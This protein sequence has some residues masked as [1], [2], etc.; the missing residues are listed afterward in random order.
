[1][2][3]TVDFYNI[4]MYIFKALLVITVVMSVVL[5]VSYSA[6]DKKGSVEASYVEYINEWEVEDQAG[7]TFMEKGGY[8]DDRMHDEDFT[9]RARLPKS[10]PDGSYVCFITRCETE[11]YID[12]ELRNKFDR[13]KDVPIRGGSVKN[14]YMLT[15]VNEKD[16][17]KVIEIF[18][19]RV[20]R[21]PEIIPEVFIAGRGGL[22]EV[23]VSKY[24]VSF[25]ISVI[26]MFI[27]T[28]VV[29]VGLGMR[30]FY[31]REIN[32]L[33]AALGVCVTSAWLITNSYLFP[34]AFGHYH[35]DGVINYIACM[36]MPI[37]FLMYVNYIQKNRYD[38][39]FT[40]LITVSFASM[41]IFTI[42][43]FT[44][45]F[46][47]TQALITI[48]III[49][50]DIITAF[51][52]VVFDI[53]K[54][55][56]KEYKYTTIG[57]VGFFFFGIAEIVVIQFIPSTNE[58]IPMLLGLTYLLAFVL[59]QQV[60]DLSNITAERERAVQLSNAKTAF[61]AN[62]S[63]EIRTPINSILGMNEMIIRENRDRKIDEYARNVQA[64]GKM[65][66]SLVNDVLDFSQ[67]EADKMKII[68]ES[69]SLT[70]ILSDIVS[71]SDE[72]ANGKG[73]NFKM[74]LDGEVPDGLETDEVRLKQ[75]LINLIN[76]AI[77]Y[78]DEGNV[79]LSVGGRYI[80]DDLYELRLSVS[81]TGRG[82]REEDKAHLFDAFSR[83]DL[84]RNRNI[85][86]TG[87]GL[88]IVKRIL[89]AMDGTISVESTYQEGSVFDVLV[90]VKVTDRTPVDPD[91]KKKDTVVKEKVSDTEYRAPGANVLAVD[92]NHS[93]LEIVRMFL[94]RVDIRPTLCRGGREAVEMCYDHKY[95][96][97]L[98]DH[99]M[100]EIDGL[101]ALKMIRKDKYSLNKE[102]PALVLT[103]NAIAGSEKIYL[104]AGFSG[105]LTKPI[106]SKKLLRTVREYLPKDK[107][108][109]DDR[110]VNKEKVMQKSM[111]KNIKE[112]EATGKEETVMGED[113]KLIDRLRSIEGMDLDG[114]LYNCGGDEGILEV[115]I[116]D[117]ISDSEERTDK[118]R[119]LAKEGNYREFG[120]EAHAL[121]GLMATIGVTGLSERAKKHE[122]AAKEGNYAFIDGDY[123]GLIGE[124]ED[125]CR[126]MK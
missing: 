74:E 66:L 7:N 113:L 61:L 96:L 93:N 26:L 100:P 27:S 20:D 125:L 11:V 101:Q 17:D 36:L 107:I 111:E 30:F 116:E 115:V 16:S 31:K 97:I 58:G 29:L 106:D 103:A 104:N 62:M 44:E 25:V 15:P 91:L 6:R 48:D 69:I 57:F 86:G 53:I 114:A 63:H 10:I 54:G 41:I 14:F 80:A 98:L 49:L 82:I 84:T 38:K 23:L 43:H 68:N 77:K 108:L 42:L 40:F 121:K 72:R 22:Y 45:V 120:I 24:G 110:T 92:D 112:P 90:P 21:R 85:E 87:L 33:Y 78:T 95:D 35:I 94:E 18:R 83:A 56:A 89:D 64:S 75:I 73:L 5:L 105:Y 102:T 12:G 4:K 119:K 3:K 13:F 19:G 46:R 65:L 34:F 117:I 55:S 67:L 47:F 76:N 109:N 39:V 71:M 59:L 32:M 88:A 81:D 28:L 1:M 123:E 9:I 118:M 37:P 51:V 50:I 126:K 60:V 70:T 124:F 79:T 2:K 122:F 99:M 52:L 8:R